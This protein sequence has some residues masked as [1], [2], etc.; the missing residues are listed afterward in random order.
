MRGT[1][2][3]LALAGALAL[4]MTAPGLARHWH[5]DDTAALV[6][7]LVLGGIAAAAIS[8][9]HHHRD[10]YIPPAPAY[11]PAAPFSPARGVVCYPR[12]GACYDND[13]DFLPSWTHRVF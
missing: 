13:G 5:S 10:Q 8:H 1:L 4:S 12:E 11:Q 3:R 7:G 6:G 2:A 9:D